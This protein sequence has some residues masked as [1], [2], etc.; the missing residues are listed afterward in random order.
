MHVSEL[1]QKT[2]WVV[3][4]TDPHSERPE[5][6]DESCTCEDFPALK[7]AWEDLSGCDAFEAHSEA[8]QLVRGEVHELRRVDPETG[9]EVTARRA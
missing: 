7:A 4:K 2:R 3:E 9:V 1:G 8:G 6:T 5:L